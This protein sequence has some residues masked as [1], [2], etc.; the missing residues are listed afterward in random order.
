MHLQTILGVMVA[1]ALLLLAG[2]PVQAQTDVP[3][4][5]G[6]PAFTDGVWNAI[7]ASAGTVG[8]GEGT[9]TPVV[10]GSGLII[11]SSPLRPVAP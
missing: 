1:S 4:L 7:F 2:A 6:P 11:A 9:G 5:P 8:I 10:I 3:L